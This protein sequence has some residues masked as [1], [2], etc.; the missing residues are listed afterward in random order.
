MAHIFL[1]ESVSSQLA[2]TQ[3]EH[4]GRVWMR[5]AV[6]AMVSKKQ[7]VKGGDKMKTDNVLQVYTPCD[8]H[9]LTS[10]N[11]LTPH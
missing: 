10:S 6:H 5:E 3:E 11:F 4:G 9:L 7:R 8:Q 2:Q 1:E